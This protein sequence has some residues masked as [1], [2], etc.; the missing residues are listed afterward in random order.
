MTNFLEPICCHMGKNPRTK[1]RVIK[2]SR[3]QEFKRFSYFPNFLVETVKSKR[4]S[5][6]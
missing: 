2:N 3:T 6:K 1:N 5:F 4:I